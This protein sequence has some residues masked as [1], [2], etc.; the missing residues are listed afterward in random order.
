MPEHFGD[1]LQKYG[2]GRALTGD[3]SRDLDV[4]PRAESRQEIEFLEDESDF[5]FAQA[6]ALSIGKCREIN[7]VDRRRCP[8]RRGS[9]RRACRRASTCRFP[10]D[11][12]W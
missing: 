1:L 11:Q 10:K 9:D 5:A 6:R 4:R 3:V 7:A 2:I 12:Q 8:S